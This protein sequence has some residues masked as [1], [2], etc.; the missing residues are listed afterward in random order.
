MDEP[1]P[2]Y[3]MPGLATDDSYA[4]RYQQLRA[5]TVSL[6]EGLTAED[7]AVQSMPDASPTKWHLGH[8]SWFFET[9]VLREHLPGYRVFDA[10]FAYLFNSYYESAGPRHARFQRGLLTRPPLEQVLAYRQHVDEAVN[11]LLKTALSP[12]L[13]I[14]QKIIEIG[15]HHEMQ[16]QELIL[17]DILH[18]FSN[19]PLYPAMQS[20]PT[21]LDPIASAP[22][23]FIRFEGGVIDI[24]AND[25]PSTFSYDCERPRHKVWID[26]FGL[27]ERTVT[28]AQWLE[29][30]A[31]QGYDEPLLWLSDG[32]QQRR[33]ADWT[34]PG[35]WLQ[36]DGDQWYQ[37]GL[38][39]LTPV[40]PSAPVCHISYY[41]ADAFARWAGKRLPTEME[42]EHAARHA[43]Q[44]TTN[45]L[46]DRLWQPAT[47]P[48]SGN[49]AELCDL[50]GNV[51]EWTGS[52]FSPY[53]GFKAT[54]GALAEYN[55]K[56][57]VNQ[58]VLRGGSC[59]TP[60]LQIRATYRNF[61]Y[62]HQRWQFSGLRLADQG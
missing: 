55:G 4:R 32:W 44:G 12:Q 47:R 11:Q 62:P 25:D 41:E 43:G 20:L 21:P 13:D 36:R 49:A 57:M 5:Q 6:C 56:F 40:D 38:N 34:A 37:F 51:W 9:F 1:I 18:L 30:M 26:S 3:R 16:H 10:T 45:F 14:I 15:L 23:R 46:E 54:D 61:F 22:A 39:G 2:R 35:Y 19:N 33:T 58:M 50:Y 31:D 27:A 24:G 60:R 8:T 59:V 29:F 52:P 17:T 48:I 53:P 42:W 28:N 7:M